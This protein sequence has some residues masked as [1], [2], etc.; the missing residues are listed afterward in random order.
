MG[1][2]P[3]KKPDSV[4]SSSQVEPSSQSKPTPNEE[5]SS[6]W[7]EILAKETVWTLP[8][9][10]PEKPDSLVEMTLSNR[11]VVDDVVFAELDG[12][13]LIGG[14]E[15]PYSIG[16]PHLI[17]ANGRRALL[18]GLH[19]ELANGDDEELIEAL[20]STDALSD[21]PEEFVHYSEDGSILL[22]IREFAGESI[23]CVGEGPPNDEDFEC[24]DTCFAT[25]CFSK[26]NG[27]VYLDGT[28]APED[29]IF[30][31][32]GYGTFY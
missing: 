22:E 30:R 18:G 24:P 27:V 7:L 17:V 5:R 26:D 14:K 13:Y 32:A 1:C 12:R 15:Q 20:E 25:L 4:P 6:F 16:G 11:R 28:W 23:Y 19:A 10:E 29:G 3:S 2:G 9:V 8:E 31:A 21:P